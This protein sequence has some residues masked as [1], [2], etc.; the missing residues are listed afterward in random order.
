MLLV[1]IKIFHLISPDISW[2]QETGFL[3]VSLYSTLN[4]QLFQ[5]NERGIKDGWLVSWLGRKATTNGQFQLISEAAHSHSFPFSAPPIHNPFL[6][7]DFLDSPVLKSLGA[8]RRLTALPFRVWA[9]KGGSVAPSWRLRR[10]GVHRTA[11]QP[12]YGCPAKEQRVSAQK[13]GLA[14]ASRA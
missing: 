7:R 9:G 8:H 11:A 4:S 5:H 2:R 10:D 13:G 1:L 14:R 3:E 6:A 12:G